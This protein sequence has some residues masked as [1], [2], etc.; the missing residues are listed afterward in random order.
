[1]H[2][3]RKDILCKISPFYFILRNKTE[4]KQYKKKTKQKNSETSHAYRKNYTSKYTPFDPKNNKKCCHLRTVIPIM[5]KKGIY[6]PTLDCIY[7]PK[8]NKTDDLS[9]YATDSLF[10]CLLVA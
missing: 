4:G 6:F 9:F 5:M 7:S 8:S 10:V 2:A 1:M 3:K